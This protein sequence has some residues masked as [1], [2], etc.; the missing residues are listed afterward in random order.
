MVG[1]VFGKHASAELRCGRGRPP[2]EDQKVN[3]ALRI[4]ADVLAA[5]RQQGKS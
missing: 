4:D 2:K 5:Y 3:Q 1:E